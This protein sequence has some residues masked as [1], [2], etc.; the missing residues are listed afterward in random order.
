[1][2]CRSSIKPVIVSWKLSAILILALGAL[3]SSRADLILEYKFDETGTNAPSTGSQTTNLYLFN[4]ANVSTDLHGI[5]TSGVSGSSTDRAL[6]LTMAL[7]MGSSPGSAD[8]NTRHTADLEAIDSLQSFTLSGWFKTPADVAIGGSA[9]LIDNITASSFTNGFRLS[10]SGTALYLEVD[11]GSAVSAGTPSYDDKNRWVFFAVTYDGTASANNVKFY[12]GYRTGSEARQRGILTCVSTS[13]LD[14]AAV[15]NDSQA[16]Y[17][18][19]RSTRLRPFKGF[20]DNVRIHGSKT[21]ATGALSAAQLEDLRAADAAGVPDSKMLMEYLFN[22]T[23]TNALGSGLVPYPLWLASSNA[24]ATD[25]HGAAGTGVS[26]KDTD[27]G[28]DL[29]SATAWGNQG[30]GPLGKQAADYGEFDSLVSFTLSGWFKTLPGEI[31]DR[32]AKLFSKYPSTP[33]YGIDLAATGGQLSLTVDGGTVMTPFSETGKWVFFAVTYNG[34]LST[35]N[36]KFYKGFRKASEGGG[37][38][39]VSCVAT[40]TIDKGVTENNSSALIIGNSGAYDRPFKGWLDNMRLFGSY[41]DGSGALTLEQIEALRIGDYRY[42]GG[43]V[44]VV[45]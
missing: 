29:T 36:V 33:T 31:I 1:M 44:M 26:E 9:V 30:K 20:L 11:I 18:G 5:V 45:R 25:Y 8:V 16:L 13:T 34:S 27:R 35:N 32:Y 15:D 22:E 39:P 28:L 38:T 43:S 2:N 19:N 6:D 7:G 14:K 4:A 37:F 40:G 12:R 17:V 21:D 23:G 42:I 10:C 24:V 3:C 41:Q